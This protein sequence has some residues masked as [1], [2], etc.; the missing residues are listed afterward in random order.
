M[1]HYRIGP[2]RTMSDHVC[3]RE[4]IISKAKPKSAGKLASGRTSYS[5]LTTATTL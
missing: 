4:I 1:T 5:A 3:K 2:Y